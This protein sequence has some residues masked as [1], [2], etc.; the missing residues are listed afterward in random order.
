MK[1]EEQEIKDIII[2]ILSLSVISSL[3]DLLNG[4]GWLLTLFFSIIIITIALIVKLYAHKRVA[5]RFDCSVV[6]K[7]NYNLFILSLLIAFITNGGIVFAAIGSIIV[8]SSLFTRL[9]HKYVNITDREKGIIALSGPMANVI[10]ALISLVFYPLS[11]T[12]FQLSLNL[13]VFFALFNMI[14]FPPL[15]GAKILWWSRMVWLTSFIIPIFLFFFR[16]NAVFSLVGIILL[17][18]ITFVLWQKMF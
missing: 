17:V 1:F 11:N 6:Y 18:L 3:S 8:S 16:F 2:T 15:D 10:L 4:G 9:G 14:P 7:F 5:E 13:N 12:F